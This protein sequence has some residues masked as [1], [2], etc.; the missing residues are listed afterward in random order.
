MMRFIC[1]FLAPCTMGMG[2]TAIADPLPISNHS[3][4]DPDLS[5]GGDTWTDSNINW[6]DD[7][8]ASS[9]QFTEL[10]SGFAAD[11][12]NHAALNNVDADDNGVIDPLVQSLE[13]VYAA[14]TR[15]VL[16]VAVG[17]RS[18]FVN[19]G[20]ESVIRL[21]DAS[22][23]LAL[24]ESVIDASLIAAGTFADQ[25]LR[26]STGTSDESIGNPIVI[27]L[28][29]GDVAGGRAHFDNVR[30][31]AFTIPEPT[32]VFLTFAATVPV[33]YAFRRRRLG[34]PID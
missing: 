32:T 13:A 23:G 3:F 1:F 12:V 19:A 17:H 18:G 28:G 31:D 10:I 22:S 4:E 5:T 29:V 6:G 16:T 30:L 25:T 26:Y 24:A 21:A 33:L 34:R 14:N 20:N 11:G 7:G 8:A 15:Y 9:E 2:A 27:E